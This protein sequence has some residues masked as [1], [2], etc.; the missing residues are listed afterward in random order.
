MGTGLQ[1]NTYGNAQGAYSADQMPLFVHSIGTS[2][3]LVR[4]LAELPA[5]ESATQSLGVSGY[6]HFVESHAGV[7]EMA[8]AAIQDCLRQSATDPV[9]IE[10]VVISTE[11]F[12]DCPPELAPVE[13]PYRGLRRGF[14]DVLHQNGVVNAQVHGSWMSGC[15]NLG[16]ALALARALAASPETGTVMIV[17]TDRCPTAQPRLQHGAAGLFSDVATACLLDRERA[18]GAFAIR[19]SVQVTSSGIVRSQHENNH[20]MTALELK[21]GLI[22][23]EARAKALTRRE[24]RSFQYV[25]TENL[26]PLFTLPFLELLGIERTT[27]HAPSRAAFGHAYSSDILLSLRMIA[28]D[29]SV[30]PGTEIL[31]IIASSW[32]LSAIVLEKA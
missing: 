26:N 16:P 12:W 31:A 15:G 14:I 30:A 22:A 8:A 28:D 13:R 23:L 17:T 6:E 9:G 5:A 29:P 21:K 2:S 3:G 11:S 7:V 24:F 10:A 32:S 4:S 20:L 18:S 19:R 1:P 27:I 25:L